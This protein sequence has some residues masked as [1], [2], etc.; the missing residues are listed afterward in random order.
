MIEPCHHALDMIFCYSM[1]SIQSV[2]IF[3]VLCNTLV[4]ENMAVDISGYA[5]IGLLSPPLRHVK[6]SSSP[7]QTG[8]SWYATQ[9]NVRKTFSFWHILD[10]GLI[11]IL[12][13]ILLLIIGN[14]QQKSTWRVAFILAYH[15]LCSQYFEKQ[16]K[17]KHQV[18]ECRK[19]EKVVTQPKCLKIF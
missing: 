19:F 18:D 15:G 10:L 2:S 7:T 8:M 5:D 4:E 1:N 9:I 11:C 16:S 17:S 13:L 14:V 6:T 12:I 3:I